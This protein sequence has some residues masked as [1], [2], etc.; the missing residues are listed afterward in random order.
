MPI[1]PRNLHIKY[2]LNTTSDKGI[3]A[4][5][6]WLL[7]TI[8]MRQMADAYCLKEPPYQIWT[9]YDLR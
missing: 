8:A 5:L 2:G 3:S 7:V 6:L 1:V 9:Q 4:I